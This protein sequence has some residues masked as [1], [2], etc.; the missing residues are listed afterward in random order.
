MAPNKAW[1]IFLR[2]PPVC[3]AENT[4]V[5]KQASTLSQI[6]VGSQ[7]SSLRMEEA[8]RGSGRVVDDKAPCLFQ[9]V[10]RSFPGNDHVMHVTFPQACAAD[11]DEARLLLQLRNVPGAAVAHAGAQPAHQLIDHLG[12]RAT[13]RNAPF[14]S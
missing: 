14:N 10:I 3:S 5:E 11:A 6:N 4:S 9:P 8:G 13:I 1:M 7:A 12:Q 2:T